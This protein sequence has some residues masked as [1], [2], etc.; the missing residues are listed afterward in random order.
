MLGV[1]VMVQDQVN[2]MLG[3]LDLQTQ[4]VAYL[5]EDNSLKI[6]PKLKDQGAKFDV[7]MLDGDHNY[8][9]V[10]EELKVIQ[11]IV[12]NDAI[13]VVDDYDGRWSER[14]LFYSERPEY[15]SNALTTKK[16]ETEKHG[17]K[18]AVDE[19]LANNHAWELFKPI[20]GEPVLLKRR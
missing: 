8:H 15:A 13:I 6:L 18:A 2:I 5:V 16:V 7:V 19:W 1:D 4:Q 14:D 3:N 17:V 11:D 9:T 20:M 12:S 10:S